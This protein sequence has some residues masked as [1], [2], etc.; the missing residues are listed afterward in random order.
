[1][2]NDRKPGSKI[3]DTPPDNQAVFEPCDWVN[4]K[5]WNLAQQFKTFT[6]INFNI[7]R[8]N[9][10][11]KKNNV[12]EMKKKRSVNNNYIHN[13]TDTNIFSLIGNFTQL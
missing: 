5:S 2:N 11:M 12:N 13:Q 3:Y 6:W 4:R 7:L 10:Q 1:M 9:L 8:G